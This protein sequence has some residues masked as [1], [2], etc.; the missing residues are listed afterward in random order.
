VTSGCV[1][2]F[3]A[4]SGPRWR[5]AIPLA[6]APAAECCYSLTIREASAQVE[7]PLG[8]L[9]T[10]IILVGVVFAVAA[11][12]GWVAFRG[13]NL[14][15]RLERDPKYKR[16]FLY[17]QAAFYGFGIVFAVAQVLRGNGPL[18]V[19]LALPIPLLLVWHYLRLAKQVK[20]PPDKT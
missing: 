17:R 16:Q 15:D 14:A 3:R 20:I 13:A 11:L 1:S 4:P 8:K 18:V 5:I 2:I 19:L 6:L 9:W 10:I 12:L 7:E